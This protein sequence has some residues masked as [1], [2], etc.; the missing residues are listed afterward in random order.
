MSTM[1]KPVLDGG[2]AIAQGLRDLGIDYVFSSPGSEWAPV[3][4]AFARQKVSKTAGPVFLNTSHEMLAVDLAIGYTTITGRMQAVLLHAGSGLMHGS[5]GISSALASAIPMVVISGECISY[6]DDDSYDPGAQWYAYLGVVGGAQRLMEPL[7]KWANQAASPATLHAMVIRTGEMA[8]RSPTGPAYLCVPV[9]S[10]VHPW[11]PPKKLRKVAPAPKTL[12]PAADVEKVAR[13]LSKARNPVITTES[14][15]RDR[16]SYDRL[17]ELAELLAI[18]VVESP[19]ATVS[20]FPKDHPLHRGFDIKPLLADADLVLVVRNR[21]P[22]YPP[23]ARPENATVV[24][25]DETPFK[26]YMV[27]QNYQADLFL[28]GD[29]AASLGGLIDAVRSARP[30]AAAI[31]ARN[32]KWAASHQRAEASDRAEVAKARE[33]AAI[34]PINLCATLGEVLPRDTIYVDETTSHRG[35]IHRY[36]RHQGPWSF[37][38]TPSGLGQSLG[39]SLGVKLASPERPVVALVGDGA[40]HYNPVIPC[41]G[42]A[43]RARLPILIVVFN[44]KGYRSMG[45]NQRN[46]YPDGAGAR[47]NLLYGLTISVADYD[48]LAKPFGGVGIR[49]EDPAKLTFALRE[50]WAAVNNGKTAIINVVLG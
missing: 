10:L 48:Q 41:L 29:V 31:K 45:N 15:G 25:I 22:W 28:E 8:Q 26:S 7:V 12:A 18:P 24:V 5:M 30:Q 17:I 2:E 34:H 9:E 27:Y 39:M 23:K 14:G 44:N 42:F 4:E 20:N 32:A 43:Q 13:L 35:L 19:V 50:G 49:V 40:F 11:T 36:V 47:H 38:R 1:K 6:G 46:D 33:N 21:V 3:W 16:D 37:I